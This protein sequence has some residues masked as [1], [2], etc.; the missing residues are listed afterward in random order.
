MVAEFRGE[1]LVAI[2]IEPVRILVKRDELTFE[3]IEQF[4]VA[5]ENGSSVL[6][7]IFMIL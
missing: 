3:G 2:A 5:V 7:E 6:C 4:F 1:I